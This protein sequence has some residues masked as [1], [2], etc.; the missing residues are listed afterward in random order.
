MNEDLIITVQGDTYLYIL[1]Q[2][3]YACVID[4]AGYQAVKRVLTDRNL[5]LKK[6]LNTHHH[7]DHTGGNLRLKE[8]YGCRILA[9]SHR[10]VGADW[11]LEEGDTVSFAGLNLSVIKT[12]GHTL[13]SLCFFLAGEKKIIFTGDTLFTA[14]CGRL[15][16][17]TPAMMWESMQKLKVLPGDTQVCPGHNY[18]EE[19]LAF[20]LSL[21]PQNTFMLEFKKTARQKF[22]QGDNYVKSTIKLEKKINPF[23]LAPDAGELGLI[24]QKKD[25]F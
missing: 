23:M 22:N 6:I 18:T 25:I 3:G 21:F 10:A 20:A 7:F 16:E 19:N 24:R 5:Q 4:T 8:E 11:I 13:D 17:G 15:F 9:G 1:Q 14:G 2:G 12:P